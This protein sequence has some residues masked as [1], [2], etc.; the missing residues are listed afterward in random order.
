MLLGEVADARQAGS[1]GGAERKASDGPEPQAIKG[2][3]SRLRRGKSMRREQETGLNEWM[4]A[5]TDLLVVSAFWFLLAPPAS[6]NEQSR[7]ESLYRRYKK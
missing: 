5:I 2:K 7:S 3:R 4:R 1:D 6:G